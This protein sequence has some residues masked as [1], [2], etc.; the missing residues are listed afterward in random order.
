MQTYLFQKAKLIKQSYCEL[1]S[2]A[3]CVVKYCNSD[4]NKCNTECKSTYFKQLS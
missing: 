2:T 4:V 1:L 3:N